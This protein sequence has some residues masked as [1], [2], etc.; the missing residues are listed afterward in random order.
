MINPFDPQGV[1]PNFDPRLAGAMMS[2]GAQLTQPAQFGQSPFGQAMGALAQGGESVRSQEA[3]D[4]KK[5][6]ADSRIAQRE[7]AAN[8]A[9]ARAGTASRGLDVAQARLGIAQSEAQRKIDQLDINKRTQAFIE[10]NK[11]VT[12][13]NKQNQK[14]RDAN[15]SG[16]LTGGTKFTPTIE[17]PV[18]SP[19]E[20]FAKSGQSFLPSMQLS[21]HSTPPAVTGT[22]PD[23]STPPP[24]GTVRG[25]YKYNGG[26]PKLQSS[27]SEV[28]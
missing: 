1:D 18:L 3:Q 23:F 6:E 25:G 17:Q 13:V 19:E 22:A 11:Y 12:A 20:W 16:K 9:E 10:Y 26:D 2:I 14:I 24:I 27:W 8:L 15:E 7:A 28:K 4:I 21:P 5:Q